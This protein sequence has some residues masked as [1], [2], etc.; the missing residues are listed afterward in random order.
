MIFPHLQ[1][2]YAISSGKR[3]KYPR[4]ASENDPWSMAPRDNLIA[5]FY[6]SSLVTRQHF[7]TPSLKPVGQLEPNFIFS[8]QGQG[9]QKFVQMV[10][11]CWPIGCISIKIFDTIFISIQNDRY[12]IYH[13][14]F[15]ES[16]ETSD[17][18][19]LIKMHTDFIHQTTL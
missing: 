5:V 13:L 1:I 11:V 3:W 17:L 12:S 4:I 10:P 14:I 18:Y 19:V 2:L 8:F 9:E 16:T 7:Q 6:F 15:S